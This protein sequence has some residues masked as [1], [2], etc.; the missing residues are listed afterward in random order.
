MSM[1]VFIQL[2]FYFTSQTTGVQRGKNG[3][4]LFWEIQLKMKKKVFLR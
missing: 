2:A 4:F 1:C 3:T